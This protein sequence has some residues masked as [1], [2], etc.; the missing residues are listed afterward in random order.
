MK[1]QPS[2]VKRMKPLLG[3][4]VE[5]G[6]QS[7]TTDH[8]TFQAAFAVIEA[9]QTQM[10]FHQ[11]NSA[12][13]KLNKSSGDWVELPPETLEVL[14][15]ADRLYRQTDGLFNCTLAGYLVQR[16]YLPNHFDQTFQLSGTA[17]SLEIGEDS[18][19]LNEPVL[20]TLDG[21]A[22]G[23]AV[24]RAVQTLQDLQV[25][26]GWINAGGDIRVFGDIEI[27]IHQR[28]EW[29][30]LIPLT[31]LK[32]RALATSQISHSRDASY[33]S[34]I[35]NNQGVQPENTI[36]SVAAEDAWLADALTKVLAI[37]PVNQR[38]SVAQKFSATYFPQP[39]SSA[40]NLSSLA[41]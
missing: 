3:T 29:Y 22:K 34:Y 19:R 11:P 17:D 38:A 39:Q 30:Q 8:Q 5:I 20:I 13:S 28:N 4:Y 10:S 26:T 32:N 25:T 37:T 2:I 7:G 16:Q 18:A 31:Q 14:R 27:P 6:F 40:I 33:P 35:I 36:I 21:I 12:L 23:Y 15:L 41:L 9:I 24:D 1:N